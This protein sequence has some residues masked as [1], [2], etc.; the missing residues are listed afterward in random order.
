MVMDHV[1]VVAISRSRHSGS[2]H[3]PEFRS[4]ARACEA[5]VVDRCVSAEFGVRRIQEH[6]S[7]E[8]A[9]VVEPLHGQVYVVATNRSARGCGIVPGVK[10]NAA[11]ALAASLRVF[12]R[13]IRRE[14]ASLES[15]SAWAQTLTSTVSFSPPDAV[16]L[17]VAGS[18]RL[19]GSLAAIKH[20]LGEELAK[21]RWT[22]RLCAA[23]T[24]TAALWLA[25]GAIEDVDSLATLSGKLG[26]LPVRV[27]RWP[28]EVQALLRD[29][30]VRTIADCLRLPRDGFAR[31]VVSSICTISTER[32]RGAS[33][34]ER[35]S[36][37]MSVGARSASSIRRLPTRRFSWRQSRTCSPP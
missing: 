14:R 18:V 12:E 17:E 28:L 11:F 24:A 35:A 26:S 3:R 36:S 9:V 6:W 31:R 5:S 34:R 23:P 30:G 15:L 20:K 10:L 16:L 4:R 29:L 2:R 25:R 37:P 7:D 13:S 8:P 19:F 1:A 33:I 32:S 21:R 27:T 22:Q